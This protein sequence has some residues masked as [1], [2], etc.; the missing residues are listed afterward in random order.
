MFSKVGKTGI[1]NKNKHESVEVY[2]TGRSESR[3]EK[4]GEY[5]THITQYSNSFQNNKMKLT[6]LNLKSLRHDS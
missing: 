4:S 3:L 6:E 5:Y 2:E 1:F